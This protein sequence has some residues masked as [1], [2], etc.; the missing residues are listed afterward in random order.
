MQNGGGRGATYTAQ[1]TNMAWRVDV[2][3]HNKACSGRLGFCATYMYSPRLGKILLPSRVHA[4][5]AANA[6]R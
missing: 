1:G 2:L 3:L 4:Y 5:P 6:N